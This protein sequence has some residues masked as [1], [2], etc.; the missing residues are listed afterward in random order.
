MKSI[1]KLKSVAV[2]NITVQNYKTFPS[3][4]WG[5]DG[6]TSRRY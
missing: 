3:M 2:G 6:G 5:E 1:K 4:E